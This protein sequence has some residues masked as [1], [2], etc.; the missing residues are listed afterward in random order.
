MVRD[1]RR[2][3]P[4]MTAVMVAHCRT[5]AVLM[6]ELRKPSSKLDG[7]RGS[8]LIKTHN[9]QNPSLKLS[10]ECSLYRQSCLIR[11][12][13]PDIARGENTTVSRNQP[14]PKNRLSDHR[15]RITITS[16]VRLHRVIRHTRACYVITANHR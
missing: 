2:S 13:S 8:G 15:R 10:E 3:Q 4:D 11:A 1:V 14:I 12:D 7:F 6:P 5:F 9:A 16:T